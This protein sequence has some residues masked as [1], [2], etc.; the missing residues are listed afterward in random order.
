MLVKQPRRGRV[1]PFHQHL[2][3]RSSWHNSKKAPSKHLD[4]GL[5]GQKAAA[6]RAHL[7]PELSGRARGDAEIG[8]FQK[9]APAG[10][11][12]IQT[13]GRDPVIRSLLRALVVHLAAV[14]A[15][16]QPLNHRLPMQPQQQRGLV[17]RVV[18]LDRSHARNLQAGCDHARP[19]PSGVGSTRRCWR[20]HST[21]ETAASPSASTTRNRRRARNKNAA[22]TAI[23]FTP[24]PPPATP[25]VHAAR[26]PSRTSDSNPSR[27]IASPGGSCRTANNPGAPSPSA[28]HAP[29]TAGAARWQ[30]AR[31]RSAPR[32]PAAAAECAPALRNAAIP[33]CDDGGRRECNAEKDHP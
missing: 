20:N 14:I 23:T 4:S 21:A 3:S 25:A 16:E 31:P 6:P 2:L 15:A 18:H 13:A 32:R 28:T 22:I 27:T 26:S 19:R 11:V 24:A 5:P 9:N 10:Q 12:R 29:R 33:T 7:A 30:P 8:G 1:L 17:D